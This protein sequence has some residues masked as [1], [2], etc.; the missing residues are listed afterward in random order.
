MDNTLLCI[1]E[2]EKHLG[3]II[4]AAKHPILAKR[5]NLQLKPKILLTYKRKTS[6]DKSFYL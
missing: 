3:I 1:K 4:S 5:K 2:K 6:T